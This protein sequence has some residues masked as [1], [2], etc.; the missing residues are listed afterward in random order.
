MD[1]RPRLCEQEAYGG[2]CSCGAATERPCQH[3]PR[4]WLVA[5]LSSQA[6]GRLGLIELA[7]EAEHVALLGQCQSGG[8]RRTLHLVSPLGRGKLSKGVLIGS[9][10][11][12]DLSS[13]QR[14]L[15]RVRD[16]ARLCVAPPG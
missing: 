16:K 14:A 2:N 15:A 12:H 7:L 6:V 1:W 11:S 10:Q 13:V 8:N 9:A 4:L 5:L 3:E